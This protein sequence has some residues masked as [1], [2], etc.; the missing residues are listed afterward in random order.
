MFII[1]KRTLYPELKHRIRLEAFRPVSSV[2]VQ[3]KPVFF[4]NAWKPQGMH[5]VFPRGP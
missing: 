1:L 5:R 3:T 4:V 2:V